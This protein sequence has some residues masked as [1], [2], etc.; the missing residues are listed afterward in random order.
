MS[1]DRQGK[2]S[3]TFRGKGSVTLSLSGAAFAGHGRRGGAVMR[4][5]KEATAAPLCGSLEFLL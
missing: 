4:K 1:P 2:G 5:E 3:V